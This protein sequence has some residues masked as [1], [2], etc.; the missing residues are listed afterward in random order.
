MTKRERTKKPKPQDDSGSEAVSPDPSSDESGAPGRLGPLLLVLG[1]VVAVQTFLMVGSFYPDPHTGGD[2][3]G[4]LTLAHSLVERGAYLDLYD[5][6]EPPHTKYPPIFPAILAVAM[7]LGAKSWVAF[8]AIPAAFTTLAIGFTFLWA[9]ERKGLAVA[10][11]VALLVG[12]SDAFNYGSQW[13][14]SDPTFVA[15]TFLALWAFER[16][17]GR[18]EEVHRGWMMLG[19][20]AAILAYF[21]RSAG[22]PLLVGA[23]GWLALRRKWKGLTGLAVAFGVPAFLWWLRGR[24][25]GAQDYLSEFWLVNPYAP[26]LGRVGIGDFVSR[27]VENAVLYLGT[28]VPAGLTGF[29]GTSIT[30]GGG[31]LGALALLG[32]WRRSRRKLSAV[33]IFF[34]LYLGLILV[35]PAV[36]AGDRFALPLFPLILL[37][38]GEALADGA[39]RLHRRLPLVAVSAAMALLIAPAATSWVHSVSVAR[40]CAEV[41]EEGGTFSCHPDAVAEFVAAAQTSGEHLPD[42]AVVLTRKPR[43]FYVLSG[44]VKSRRVPL[45]DD[46]V[47]FRAEALAAGSHYALV[48]D[49]D[50]LTSRYLFP[51]IAEWPELFCSI[52][53]F[54]RGEEVRTEIFGI[55]DLSLPE[56]P[57]SP[58]PGAVGE[59]AQELR[60]DPF[61]ACP[62]NLLRQEPRTVPAAWARIV[63]LLASQRR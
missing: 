39:R 24:G 27:V 42:G 37:Y 35:W 3:A 44:G 26:E 7:L 28:H 58:E 15:L 13:I 51:V 6:A 40:A 55:P 43:L 34:P 12:L 41:R 48:D 32:W 11:A 61:R 60:A 31:L 9:Q 36:W 29:Q 45:T 21:T 25:Q 46:P 17:E 23:A 16:S 57:E 10:A 52:V 2:N 5:P 33:E 49:L 18:E 8:K 19:I 63:P 1:I 38:A 62:E 4:Y 22:L 59:G 30:V 56:P 53:A 14:L 47:A 20:A 54:P 50:N